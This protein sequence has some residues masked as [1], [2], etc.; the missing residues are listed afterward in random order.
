V[1]A[2]GSS[3]VLEQV[4]V[5]FELLPSFWSAMRPV[6]LALVI[7]LLR[8]SKHPVLSLST[9]LTSQKGTAWGG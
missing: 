3:C 5:A 7:F 1:Y 6:I 4:S 9:G 2:L 8:F